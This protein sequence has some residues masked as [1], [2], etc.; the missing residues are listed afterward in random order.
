MIDEIEE[1]LVRPVQILED[2]ENG[3]ASL[4]E[5][6][7]GNRR[8]A[9]NVSALSGAFASAGRSDADERLEVSLDPMR[10][11]A[12]STTAQL[13]QDAQQLREGLV[14]WTESPSRMPAWA[15]TISARAQYAGRRRRTGDSGP[16][17]SR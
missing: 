13:V 12:A 3:R 1:A 8:Q 11:S 14:S 5:G 17:A 10:R 16:D 2:E 6:F 9:A 7:P 15:L 4:G